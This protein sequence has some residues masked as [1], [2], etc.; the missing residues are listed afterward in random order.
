[1]YSR[2]RPKR[3]DILDSTF[4]EVILGKEYTM[5]VWPLITAVDHISSNKPGLE[6][7]N[8]D[9]TGTGEQDGRQVLRT[10]KRFKKVTN[11]KK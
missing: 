9:K 11:V 2:G 8:G 10:I 3:A 4:D 7:I 5:Q 6:N 1:M